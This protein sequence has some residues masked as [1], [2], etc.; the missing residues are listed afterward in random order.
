[1]GRGT[2]TRDVPN[3]PTEHVT[4]ARRAGRV[5]VWETQKFQAESTNLGPMP[6]GG[7]TLTV[8]AF[9]CLFDFEGSQARLKNPKIVNPK[10]SPPPDIRLHARVRHL[11]PSTPESKPR[12][13]SGEVVHQMVSH[14]PQHITSVM[15]LAGLSSTTPGRRVSRDR[16]SDGLNLTP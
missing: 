16:P 15:Q 7:G 1:M 8:V 2:F 9:L 6:P 14:V 4:P 3:E 10:K 13:R 5:A 12:R 11:R